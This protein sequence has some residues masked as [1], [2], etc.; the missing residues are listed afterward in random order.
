MMMKNLCWD[1]CESQCM[2]SI[3][4]MEGSPSTEN[5]FLLHQGIL[6]DHKKIYFNINKIDIEICYKL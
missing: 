1:N 4:S 2:S 3:K 5:F 6:S